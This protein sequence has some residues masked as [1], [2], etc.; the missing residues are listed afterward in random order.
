M[1]NNSHEFSK[2]VIWPNRYPFN[3]KIK[4][5]LQL[6]L[7]LILI[8][9]GRTGKITLLRRQFNED[10]EKNVYIASLDPEF[11][12]LL[13][14]SIYESLN[15]WDA[16]DQENFGGLRYSYDVKWGNVLLSSL[17]WHQN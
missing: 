9:D 11:H 1:K 8:G 3:Y 5:L 15:C 13:F 17:I 12:H 7:Q 14:Y 10:L 16:A 6:Q 4:Q 2:T